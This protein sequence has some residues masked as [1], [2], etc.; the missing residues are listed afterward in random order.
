MPNVKTQK[1]LLLPARAGEY[2]VG[3]VPVPTPSPGEVLVKVVSAALNPIDWKIVDSDLF[4]P[5][6]SSYPF[7]AGID[8][9]GTVEDVGEGVQSL[10]KGDKMY[11]ELS[12]CLNQGPLGE[13]MRSLPSAACSRVGSRTHGPPSRSTALFPQV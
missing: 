5:I 2:S 8:G 13:A 6:I 3:V 10:V 11:A 7:I 9:A 4:S 12:P 1:A